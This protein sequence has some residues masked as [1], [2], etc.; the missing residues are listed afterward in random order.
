MATLNRLLIGIITIL[1]I[2]A[3]ILSYLLFERR[4]EFRDR[5]TV[6]AESVADVVKSLDAEGGKDI[7]FSPADPA[8]GIPEAGSLSWETYNQDPAAFAKRVDKATKLAQNV[9]NQRDFLAETIATVAF[10]LDMPVEA[11]SVDQLKQSS[12]ADAYTG[13][14][15]KVIS[16]A[17]AVR[18][19]DNAMI[20]SLVSASNAIEAPIDEQDLRERQEGQ[21]DQNGNQVSGDFKHEA[22]LEKFVD[23]ISAMNDRC[24]AYA[25][26]IVDG[27]NRVTA[28]EW[29]TNATQVSQPRVYNRALTSLMNDF[30]E[31]NK[32]LGGGSQLEERVA[33]AEEKIKAAEQDRDRITKERDELQ[34]TVN[35][36]K[37]KLAMY[38]RDAVNPSD[39]VPSDFEMDPDLEGK[40]LHV[41]AEWNFVV[42]NLGGDKVRERVQLIVAREG[43]YIGRLM[44]TKVA[45]NICVAEILP[46]MKNGIIGI[47][48]RVIV[49]AAM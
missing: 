14:A 30:D 6:L 3:A 47:D 29:E 45:K 24:D 46:Q 35:E 16:L 13:A 33:Q 41:N 4:N 12:D 1:A 49:P 25:Q 43:E 19:R 28:F 21:M 32:K 40:I 26:A 2:G 39:G 10:D 9:G 22:E 20:Q 23:N 27:I 36:Q 31:I 34:D 18:K 17:K 8:N 48:D 42:I 38:E 15:K 7:K 37:Q 11:L 44:I 5:A